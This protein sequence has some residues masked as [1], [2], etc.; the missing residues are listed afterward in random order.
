MGLF[1]QS[2]SVPHAL[3]GPRLNTTVSEGRRRPI[4]G[5]LRGD[6]KLCLS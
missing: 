2:L 5:S 6:R 4:Y 1:I 3:S